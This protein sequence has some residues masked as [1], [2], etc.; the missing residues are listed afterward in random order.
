MS[1]AHHK[2]GF[3]GRVVL[4]C[5]GLSHKIHSGF[6]DNKMC[7]RRLTQEHKNDQQDHILEGCCSGTRCCPPLVQR[8][9]EITA[10]PLKA[11]VA[12][13]LKLRLKKPPV[14][15]T[16][17]TDDRQFTVSPLEGVSVGVEVKVNITVWLFAQTAAM[18]TTQG[19]A[20]KLRC[21]GDVEEV[22]TQGA[23]KVCV[24]V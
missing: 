10:L 3:H 17:H 7:T 23:L 13:A 8:V 4:V 11:A 20:A 14:L 16:Q 22:S 19:L 15:V 6:W 18:G 12:L 24:Q 2:S 21:R 5:V 1:H 9:F